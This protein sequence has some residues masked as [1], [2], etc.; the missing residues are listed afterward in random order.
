MIIALGGKKRSGKDT[1]ANILV[2]KCGYHRVAFADPLKELCS[3]VFTIPMRFFEDDDLKEKEL[4]DHV[5][6]DYHHLDEIK[7]IVSKE[8]GFKL[9][10]ASEDYFDAYFETTIKTPRKLLQ[11]VGTELLRKHIR[12][13][14]FIVKMFS[15]IRELGGNVVISDARMKNER[16]LL[17]KAGG[18]LVLI[19][20]DT[21]LE[22]TH[23]SENDL[24]D[25]N[26]YDLVINNEKISLQELESSVLLWYT[27]TGSKLN[28]Y[29][30]FKF[31]SYE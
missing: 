4:E 30:P 13:D 14:I 25:E 18:Y 7:E 15:R 9:P 16:E 8:W 24:G 6:I 10:D 22:D 19:K 26:D 20:R 31:D 21:K 23:I 27:M 3:R 12:D 5:V 29:K 2:K 1:V 17:K 11:F 28:V